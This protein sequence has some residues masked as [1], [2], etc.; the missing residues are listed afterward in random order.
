[1]ANCALTS[2]IFLL[3]FHLSSETGTSLAILNIILYLGLSVVISL[4]L[5]RQIVSSFLGGSPC[6][7]LTLSGERGPDGVDGEAE[8]AT[9]V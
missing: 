3:I 4:W 6:L 9:R 8:Q 7:C 2:K 1:M 5:E